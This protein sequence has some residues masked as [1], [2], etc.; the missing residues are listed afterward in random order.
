MSNA[1]P[2]LTCA[3]QFLSLV[4]PH[5]CKSEG[6][7][8]YLPDVMPRDDGAKACKGIEKFKPPTYSTTVNPREVRGMPAWRSG[9]RLRSFCESMRVVDR[10]V[11]QLVKAQAERGR[12]AY[13]IFTADNGMAW[14]QKGF[15]LK[16]TPPSTRTPFYVAGPGIE[17]G[18]TDALT[19]KI[20]IAPTLAQIADADVPWA[21]GSSFMALLQGEPFAGRDELLQVMPRSNPKSYEG[22]NALRTPAWRFVRWRSGDEEL[23]DLVA[24]PWET[25]DLAAREP[26]LATTMRMRLRE[27]TA[28]APAS[29][30][31]DEASES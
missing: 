23:Y 27:L 11:R 16:H 17:P 13:F 29:T 20:D 22:W 4:A 15:S 6:K 9:W 3:T 28:A 12:P 5:P 1:S 10:T 24:D 19:S 8:C 21:D 7:Q 25:T 30:P 14:G 26:E 31:T 18:T 2:R